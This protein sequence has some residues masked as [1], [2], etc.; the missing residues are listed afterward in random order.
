MQVGGT[1]FHSSLAAK[2][3]SLGGAA[4]NLAW[5]TV[6]AQAEQCKNSIEAI[7]AN[8]PNWKMPLD[9][10]VEW[11]NLCAVE[12]KSKVVM[13]KLGRYEQTFKDL[14]I[15]AKSKSKLEKSK[16]T[17]DRD[18]ISLHLR[19]FGMSAALAK[20]FA[21]AIESQLQP[22]HA[23]AA[24]V[25]PLKNPEQDASQY[26]FFLQPH[27]LPYDLETDV[28][29]TKKASESFDA[30]KVAWLSH[31]KAKITACIEAGKNHWHGAVGAEDEASTWP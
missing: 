2:A 31:S 13:A 12:A 29:F 14:E 4:D 16:F 26:E 25:S 6:L 5:P 27:Y 20:A 21:D 3:S 15:D 30:K 22:D 11:S 23:L 10:K 19:G 28:V 8:L 7:V 17:G 18:S 9:W 1:F 24:I